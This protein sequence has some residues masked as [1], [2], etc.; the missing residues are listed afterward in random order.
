MPK[1]EEKLL[2]M[3]KQ[4]YKEGVRVAIS[5]LIFADHLE[6]KE[7]KTFAEQEMLKR[8]RT[9]NKN[10]LECFFY[11]LDKNG[12][13]NMHYDQLHSVYVRCKGLIK[14]ED[15]WWKQHM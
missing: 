12:D 14:K 15:S 9:L 3:Y 2:L 4:L 1:E 6:V 10:G 8:V 11:K 13:I 5:S 7:N